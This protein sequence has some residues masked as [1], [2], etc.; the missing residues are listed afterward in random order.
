MGRMNISELEMFVAPKRTRYFTFTR[1]NPRS[2]DYAILLDTCERIDAS[3]G[4]KTV[5][6]G[7]K[8]RLL[9]FIT[10]RGPA[11]IADDILRLLPNFNVTSL[12]RRFGSGFDWLAEARSGSRFFV[13]GPMF[14]NY[15]GHPFQQLKTQL[16]D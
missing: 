4:Y 1:V 14:H 5:R 7:Q 13:D 12:N 11:T 2:Q 9:G 3:L 15:K 16:F 6:D 8:I 10:L